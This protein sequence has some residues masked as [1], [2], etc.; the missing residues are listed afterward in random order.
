M[1]VIL[2][3]NSLNQIITSDSKLLTDFIWIS[4]CIFILILIIIFIIRFLKKRK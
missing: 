1:L 2:F 4:F 3:L